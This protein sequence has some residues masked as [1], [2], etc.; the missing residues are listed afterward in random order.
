MEF[1]SL[2][3]NLLKITISWPFVI[4]EIVGI[5]PT[6]AILTVLFLVPIYF[7]FRS[8]RMRTLSAEASMTNGVN[9]INRQ[10]R[11][12]TY[13]LPF[14]FVGG[15][16]G[17]LMAGIGMFILSR[18]LDDLL[19]AMFFGVP[20]VTFLGFIIGLW[21]GLRARRQGNQRENTGVSQD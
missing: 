21:Y 18:S 11:S 10:R 15:A 16:F 8:K 13:A 7:Y 17:F 9:A 20:A 3:L 19:L 4:L 6:V 2:F 1:L 12:W 5:S 14:A